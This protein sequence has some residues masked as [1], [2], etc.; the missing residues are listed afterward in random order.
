MPQLVNRKCARCTQRIEADY[1]GRFCDLC[2]HA[3]HHDCEQTVFP[4]DPTRQCRRCGADILSEA[5]AQ[6]RLRELGLS[7]EERER[8][9]LLALDRMTDFDGLPLYSS[10]GQDAAVGLAWIVLGAG[11]V[12]ASLF[13]L[14]SV[15]LACVSSAPLGY[16]LKRFGRALAGGQ[17]I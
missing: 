5:A 4:P 12:A 15:V 11:L 3:V 1:E 17:R 8:Q 6:A 16:G 9:E 10:Q 13:F 2:G 7:L 14:G